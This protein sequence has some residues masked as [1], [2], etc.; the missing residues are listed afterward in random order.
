M[1]CPGS[2]RY[3]VYTA[4]PEP[5]AYGGTQGFIVPERFRWAR[6]TRKSAHGGHEAVLLDAPCLVS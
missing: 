6:T 3:A 5:I 2:R 1:S 4:P